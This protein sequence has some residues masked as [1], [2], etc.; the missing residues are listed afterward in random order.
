STTN[1]P[2]FGKRAVLWTSGR[3]GCPGGYAWA[4]W[5]PFEGNETAVIAERQLQ[6]EAFASVRCVKK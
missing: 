4:Y 1:N 5:L 6:M 2:A 3:D